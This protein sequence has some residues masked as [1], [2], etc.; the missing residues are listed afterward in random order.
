MKLGNLRSVAIDEAQE[1]A[2]CSRSHS[3]LATKFQNS[4]SSV[5][6]PLCGNRQSSG[7]TVC[8]TNHS[9]LEAMS[10]KATKFQN[11]TSSVVEQVIDKAHKRSVVSTLRIEHALHIYHNRPRLR[12]KHK[13]RQTPGRQETKKST[14]R[15]H[16]KCAQ[17]HEIVTRTRKGNL[18]T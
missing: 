9:V 16:I 14:S 17:E 11:S 4:T 10:A 7:T 1:P 3:V 18:E 13:N 8:S 15:S 2:V 5:V 12:V 6:I